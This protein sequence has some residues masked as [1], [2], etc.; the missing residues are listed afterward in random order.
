MFSKVPVAKL[1]TFDLT[2][3]GAIHIM[4]RA[5]RELTIGPIKTTVPFHL[6]IM[7]DPDFIRGDF[8]TGY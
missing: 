4:K 6:A 1:V 8:D 7:D 3:N 2:R 5:L